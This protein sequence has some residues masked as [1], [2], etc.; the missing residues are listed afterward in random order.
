MSSERSIPPVWLR[1]D[2][3]DPDTTIG[4]KFAGP[5]PGHRH[6]IGGEPSFLPDP[7]PRCSCDEE[8]TF[9]GQLDSLNDEITLD[10]A[11]VIMVFVCF[12]CFEAE[13][14]VRSS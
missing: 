3:L 13:A 12:D 1:P 10:D 9:Y 2:S 14:M 5:E 7:C 4:F 11:G 8:M 6:R